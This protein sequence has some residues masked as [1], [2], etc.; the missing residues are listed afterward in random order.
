VTHRLAPIRKLLQ[1][2]ASACFHPEM[3]LAVIMG[4]GHFRKMFP[5]FLSQKCRKAVYL[6]DAWEK[7]FDF[8]EVVVK[9]LGID[10]L[11]VTAKQ[12]AELLGARLP[13]IKVAWLPEGISDEGYFFLPYEQKDIS[14]I[15]LGRKHL[16][17]HEK[18]VQP[19][20]ERGISYRYQ[21]DT[22]EIV[23]PSPD[24]FFQ[25]L[26]R[27]RISICFP[28]AL[29][30]P[31]RSGKIST[32]TRRY[33]ESM[34]AKSLILG[35]APKEMEELF[36]YSPVIE[37]D[38]ENPMRQIEEILG[39]IDRY[40]PLVER[41]FEAVRAKHLWSHRVEALDSILGA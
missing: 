34:L 3:S 12:S 30:H 18:I 27:A 21:Q 19:C 13:H 16:S 33:L 2:I 5:F 24:E 9:E 8:I 1:P 25:G 17:Y 31:E 39:N 29:T 28:S 26:T 22:S 14:L 6:F 4:V 7:H 10:T 15:Q 11:V 37:A 41:N 38:M 35:S 36:G 23:F 40:T 20:Q 32:M